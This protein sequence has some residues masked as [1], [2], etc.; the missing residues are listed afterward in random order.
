VD[1]DDDGFI[2]PFNPSSPSNPGIPG[3]PRNPSRPSNPGNPSNPSNPGNGLPPIVAPPGV[4]G[5]GILEPPEECDDSNRRDDDGCSS[6]CRSE[7]GVCGDGKVQELLGEQ[8]E[9]I[10]HDA[11]LPYDCVQCRFFSRLC[12][13]GSIDAG[14]ECDKGANNS[15]NPNAT[16]RADCSYPRCGDSI[17]DTSFN[18]ECDDGNRVSNDGCDRFCEKETGTKT[19]TQI[20]FT[21]TTLKKS[22]GTP[23]TPLTPAETK[24][25][26]ENT[27]ISF[28]QIEAIQEVAGPPPGLGLYLANNPQVL[29]LFLEN[30]TPENVNIIAER[31]GVPS[32]V[33]AQYIA[34]QYQRQ[35]FAFPGNQYPS[36]P[37]QLPLAQLRPLI[38]GTAPIGDTGPASVAVVASGMAAGIGWMRRKKK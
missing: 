1:T 34:P 23:N 12:G 38:Q 26:S 10:S 32:Q 9:A 20:A 18:E 27:T 8:C 37:Y 21:P 25:L 5:N 28:A 29:G 22:L 17:I 2:K 16:C 36:A 35:Q 31:L 3:N 4:C 11:G 6:V 14:E 7:I 33:A 24:V 30:Q 15:D 13:N 19:P